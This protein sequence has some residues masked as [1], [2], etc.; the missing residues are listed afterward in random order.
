MSDEARE[1]L[2]EAGREFAALVYH[3]TSEAHQAAWGAVRESDYKSESH[4][5]ADKVLD[6]LSACLLFARA[7][8]VRSRR[9]EVYREP[10]NVLQQADSETTLGVVLGVG[11]LRD[12]RFAKAASTVYNSRSTT[13]GPDG[14]PVCAC[15]RW[16]PEHRREK[17]R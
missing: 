9:T 5:K 12:L 1:H 13:R 15:Q 2:T 14:S 6:G 7:L 16:I 10:Q 8:T 3:L 11:E 4:K 17:P